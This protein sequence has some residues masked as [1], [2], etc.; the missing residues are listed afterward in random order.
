MTMS[1]KNK[2]K[3]RTLMLLS[4]VGLMLFKV[5]YKRGVEDTEIRLASI[6]LIK[7]FIR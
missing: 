2:K 1:K 4:I 7:E 3:I 6:I 5:G